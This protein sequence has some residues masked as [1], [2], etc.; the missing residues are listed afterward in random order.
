LGALGKVPQLGRERNTSFIELTST[1]GVKKIHK[2]CSPPKKNC[3]VLGGTRPR[4]F[5]EKVV[6]W[7]N[8]TVEPKG[9]D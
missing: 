3:G 1:G 4:F 7:K 9:Y 8:A 6:D 5:S 2:L